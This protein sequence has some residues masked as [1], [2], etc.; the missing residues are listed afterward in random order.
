MSPAIKI[1]NLYKEY[2]L[3]TIG[4]GTLREDMVSWW[5]KIKGRPDPNSII[6]QSNGKII[7]STDHILALK[8]HY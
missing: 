8:Q 3:G 6:G 5:A 1:E 7:S 2:R 4:Y